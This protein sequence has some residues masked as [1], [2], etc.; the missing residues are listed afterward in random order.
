[1]YPIIRSPQ[2][3]IHLFTTETCDALKAMDKKERKEKLA[4]LVTA[5]FQNKMPM[6]GPAAEIA[7]AVGID[8]ELVNKVLALAGAKGAVGP[9]DASNMM[10]R[11]TPV[12]S[13]VYFTAGADPLLTFGF[14]DLFD[15]VDMRQSTQTSFDILDVKN[16]ITFK[17]LK[18]GHPMDVYGIEDGIASVSK[19]EYGAAIGILD[20][21]FNYQKF[22]NLNQAVIEARAQALKKMAA[23]HFALFVAITS[24]QNQTF[25]TDD[26]T[27]INNACAGILDDLDALGFAITGN[28]VFELRANI[29]LKQRIEKAFRLTFNS[30]NSGANELVHTINR[31][32]TTGLV[33]T[34][35]YVGIAGLKTKRGVWR[36]LTAEADRD[37]LTRGSNIAYSH[38]YNAAIGEEDQWRR[39]S[40]S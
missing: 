38:S 29:L 20:D 14:E 24:D 17:E 28:E 37:I 19:L 26:I 31:K 34:T 2:R 25:A 11:D 9:D 4:G 16:L 39:C 5:F 33:A 6:P 12:T 21:W 10:N 30:P 36:D 35:Y 15:F 13:A 27:T 22:W 40:L 18:S 8:P 3:I 32:Y 23:D 7:K 1:M